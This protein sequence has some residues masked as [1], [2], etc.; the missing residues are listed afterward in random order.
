MTLT[1]QPHQWA[2]LR[3]PLGVATVTRDGTRYTVCVRFDG[4][5]TTT[6][7]ATWADAL[8]AAS[9][10][11]RPHVNANALALLTHSED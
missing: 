3:T 2:R 4:T 7:H 8:G 6:P 1:G 5:E 9:A 11:L 10:G